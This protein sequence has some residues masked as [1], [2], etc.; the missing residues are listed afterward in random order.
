MRTHDVAFRLRR[1]T[2]RDVT[3][4]YIIGSSIIGDTAIGTITCIIHRR[5]GFRTEPVEQRDNSDVPGTNH[6]PTIIRKTG[7]NK[8]TICHTNGVNGT[9]STET[10]KAGNTGSNR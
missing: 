4:R 3:I 1:G 5:E 9:N 2:A 7:N 6:R 10:T 8:H